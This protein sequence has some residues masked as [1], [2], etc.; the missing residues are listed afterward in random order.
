M[1]RSPAAPA[2]QSQLG[3]LFIIII[4]CWVFTKTT[5]PVPGPLILGT[6]D[7]YKRWE[8]EEE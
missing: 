5:S 3:H 6:P 7:L 8:S 4:V 1:F 2:L